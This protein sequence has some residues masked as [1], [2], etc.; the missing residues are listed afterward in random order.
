MEGGRVGSGGKGEVRSGAALA[1]TCGSR[2]Q[3]RVY[4]YPIEF[5]LSAT[6][7]FVSRRAR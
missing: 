5:T 7:L 4:R 1:D 3:P 2:E 6:F